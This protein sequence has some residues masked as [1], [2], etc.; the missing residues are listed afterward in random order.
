MFSSCSDYT[1]PNHHDFALFHWK[2]FHHYYSSGSPI[3]GTTELQET[4]EFFHNNDVKGPYHDPVDKAKDEVVVSI[5]EVY[6]RGLK[7]CCTN[8]EFSNVNYLSD[9]GGFYGCNV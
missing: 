6:E 7:F 1:E 4:F 2:D 5:P 8:Y 3:F 9:F